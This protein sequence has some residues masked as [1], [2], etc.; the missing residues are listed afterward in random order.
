MTD[1]TLI[2]RLAEAVAQHIRPAIPLSVDL[3]DIATIAAYLKRSPQQVRE[4]MACLPGFPKAIRLPT[5]NGRTH[6]LY[7]AAEVI[8]WAQG[9]QEK[10]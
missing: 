5:T 4:R 7:N 6:P 8:K 9:Y 1:T 10:H 2:E 3:W